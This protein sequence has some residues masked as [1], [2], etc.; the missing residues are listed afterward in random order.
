MFPKTGRCYV[1]QRKPDR[2]R[3]NVKLYLHVCLP[4]PREM[5]NA[6]F[7]N[8]KP[9]PERS[10]EIY[11]LPSEIKTHTNTVQ[12]KSFWGCGD[13]FSKR[14][15]I[16]PFTHGGS[17]GLP[18]VKRGSPG[19][20]HNFNPGITYEKNYFCRAC[21]DLPDNIRRVAFLLHRI[22]CGRGRISRRGRHAYRKI[23]RGQRNLFR[24]GA[25]IRGRRQNAR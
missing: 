7:S 2:T 21:G 23:L 13:L 4:C 10:T 25:R 6:H 20:P 1:L 11:R 3:Y 9:V 14:S 15:R 8:V 5:G 22:D 16:V 17:G 18:F 24:Q 19:N 12:F